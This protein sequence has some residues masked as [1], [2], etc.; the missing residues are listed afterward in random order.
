MHLS[1]WRFN[2]VSDRSQKV[3]VKQNSIYTHGYGS[4]VAASLKWMV[5]YGLTDLNPEVQS[6]NMALDLVD[7]VGQLVLTCTYFGEPRKADPS[8]SHPAAEDGKQSRWI[9]RIPDNITDNIGYI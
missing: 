9:V 4:K 5:Q 6:L 3:P 8:K 7:L 2:E 1:L